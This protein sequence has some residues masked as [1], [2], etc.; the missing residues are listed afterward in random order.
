MGKEKISI[1]L[2]GKL[3]IIRMFRGMYAR[4]CPLCKKDIATLTLKHSRGG[5]VDFSKGLVKKCLEVSCNDC[6]DMIAKYM[7]NMMEVI[8]DATKKDS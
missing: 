6:K 2:M 3:K 1:G 4:I 8:K 7:Q 5:K